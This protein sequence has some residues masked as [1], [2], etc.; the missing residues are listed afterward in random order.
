MYVSVRG[1]AVMGLFFFFLIHIKPG[2]RLDDTSYRKGGKKTSHH[3]N[4]VSVGAES[5]DILW[6]LLRR[7]LRWL[8]NI[9]S[10]KTKTKKC[11]ENKGW[12]ISVLSLTLCSYTSRFPFLPPS[13]RPCF[14]CSCFSQISPPKQL[15][16]GLASPQQRLRHG[17]LYKGWQL[18]EVNVRTRPR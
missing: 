2:A 5:L 12:T 16:W 7:V 18:T 10:A 9:L 4:S 3:R 6:L 13:P 8:L 17:A 11:A 14:F 15:L 1:H